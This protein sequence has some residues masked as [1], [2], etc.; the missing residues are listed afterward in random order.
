VVESATRDQNLRY[1]SK[2]APGV[3]SVRQDEPVLDEHSEPPFGRWGR[4]LEPPES[5]GAYLLIE[6]EDGSGWKKPPPS[7]A[8][9]IWHR[10]P[11][12]IT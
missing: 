4:L 11:G 12:G 10:K 1:R 3:P 5:S 8:I 9:R 7:D 6:V 2:R